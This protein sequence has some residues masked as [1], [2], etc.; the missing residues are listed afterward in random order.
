[1]TDRYFQEELDRLESAGNYRRLV[2]AEHSGCDVII[3]GRR[4]LD[5]SSNDYLGLAADIGFRKEFMAG[6]S[7]EN[8]Q[9]SSSSSRSLSGDFP[10]H[11]QVERKLAAMFGREAA[12][13][14]NSGYHMN[15]GILPAIA[16]K[17]T[18]I[19][20]DKLVHASLI[21]GIRL[22]GA[23]FCRFRHNNTEHLEAVLSREH[24]KYRQIIV[25][26][27]SVYSMDG[28]RADLERICRLK[29]IYDNVSVY[30]DEAHAFGVMGETG[31]GLAEELN[32]L[33]DIDYICGTFGKALGSVGGFIV[34][35]ATVRKYL[36]NRMRP[37]IFSTALPPLNWM[38]TSWL[39]DRLPAMKPL[40][41]HLASVSAV[42][43]DALVSY[44]LEMP[45]DTHIVPV[46][47]GESSRA[48]SLAG[49]LQD[50]GFFVLPVRPPT[51]P[52][53][54]SRL[55]LSLTAN[56]S[57]DRIESLVKVLEDEMQLAD[58]K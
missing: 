42:L 32:C 2:P 56:M 47:T 10:V 36:I 46:I 5:L 4:M 31:L 58:K 15:I 43:R 1:M 41:S 23:P 35:S 8:F 26:V 17:D 18:L 12:L 22:S 53:G 25:V 38:W 52:E 28:D 3:D 49:R 37:F 40:R 30:V 29:D 7:P 34:C 14:F 6:L 39:L 21:D 51:V 33:A 11:E 57:P 45:S 24:G 44:G 27:E 13:V 50:K 48:V 54:S 19:V 55:R 20:A 9:M 16:G